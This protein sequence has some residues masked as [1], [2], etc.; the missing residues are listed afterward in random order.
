MHRSIPS[1]P[2]PYPRGTVAEVDCVEPPWQPTRP[3]TSLPTSLVI[4]KARHI[5]AALVSARM[6]IAV[7]L[8]WG[9][10]PIKGVPALVRSHYNGGV[11]AQGW[12]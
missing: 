8:L 3:A 5:A 7:H 11:E 9:H 6:P 4:R 12:W 1:T 2:T 10:M